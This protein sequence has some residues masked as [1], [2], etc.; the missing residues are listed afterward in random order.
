M[1][2]DNETAFGSFNPDEARAVA[3][4]ALAE[5][6][7]KWDEAA[8][9]LVAEKITDVPAV[10]II[11]DDYDGSDLLMVCFY[12]DFPALLA[13]AKEGEDLFI[14][15]DN[16]L[17]Y[18]ALG[19]NTEIVRYLIDHGA[20][21]HAGDD[22]PLQA[23]AEGGHIDTV[24]LL[25]EC[26]ADIHA[27]DDL[28]LGWAISQGRTA[29]VILLLDHGAYLDQ[30]DKALSY[31]LDNG[32]FK[33]VDLLVERGASLEGLAPEQQQSYEAYKQQ[34][35][36]ERKDSIN[37]K[38]NLS[39]IFNAVVWA[40]HVPEMINLWRQVPAALQSEIDFSHVVAQAKSETMKQR[41]P[42]I[43]FK[44]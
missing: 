13:L 8:K 24:R 20:D 43:I 28:A 11:P 40:G 41:K 32:H 30:G 9:R 38:Q 29:V 10:Q 22:F 4:L 1:K 25:L 6:C 3:R 17:R 23:A 33:T 16:A 34:Q 5:L 12:G 26:G 19:G 36:A 42:K 14:D 31:A 15:D 18:A 27:D 7:V 35:Q 21:V 37:A 2:Q 39:D 44:K